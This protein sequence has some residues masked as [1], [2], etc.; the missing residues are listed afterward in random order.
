MLKHS[1]LM[2]AKEILPTKKHPQGSLKK[3]IE[4]TQKKFPNISI[5]FGVELEY[6]KEWM[7]EMNRFVN[8]TDF[9]FLIGSVHE[10][11]GALVSSSKHCHEFYESNP[12][13]Y[14]Y[15]K[16]FEVLHTMVDWGNFS[17]IGHFDICKKGGVK[18]YGPFEPTK[19]KDQIIGVLELMK[20]K[21]IG[22]ELNASGLR[23]D[24]NE[25][26]PHPDIL[27]WC[28]EVGIEYYTIGSDAHTAKEVGQNLKKALDL[29]KEVGIT[30]LSAYKN[31]QPKIFMI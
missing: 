15:T 20:K 19:Y 30:N 24:C 23:Y 6:V 3:D 1:P 17:V 8:D 29:A 21:G 4:K 31:R 18:I 22:I 2:M 14:T 7:D 25:I 5:K 11:E 9:D 28:V 12:E 27:K 10:V 13:N 26:F 16:Y